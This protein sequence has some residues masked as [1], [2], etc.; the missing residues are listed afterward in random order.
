MDTASPVSRPTHV[1]RLAALLL[2]LAFVAL[3]LLVALGPSVAD[4]LQPGADDQLL[5][6]FR[7]MSMRGV[8]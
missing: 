4:A 5:G 3:S 8:A 7:W 6:P 2:A 1:V